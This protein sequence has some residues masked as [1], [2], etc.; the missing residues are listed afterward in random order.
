M[1]KMQFKHSSTTT[2]IKRSKKFFFVSVLTYPVNQNK[3]TRP[4]TPML[5]TLYNLK[6]PSP[7][8][9]K[10]I[11]ALPTKSADTQ[12][13]YTIG[14]V[15][16]TWVYKLCFIFSLCIKTCIKLY[17]LKYKSFK[18]GPT[19]LPWVMRCCIF[20]YNESSQSLP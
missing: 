15:S 11:I 10:Q 6:T 19:K 4:D 12:C 7:V 20:H 2:T 1:H 14:T 13:I 5:E 18:M 16:T 9:A 8:P 3:K 17:S